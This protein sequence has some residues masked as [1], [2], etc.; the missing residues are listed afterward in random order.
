MF[1][2][3]KI[4]RPTARKGREALWKED[5]RIQTRSERAFD[6]ALDNGQRLIVQL[7]HEAVHVVA[8][9]FRRDAT[10][11]E[12]GLAVEFSLDRVSSAYK[13]LC[14]RDLPSFFRNAR[15]KFRELKATDAAIRELR[16]KT[17]VDAITPSLLEEVFGAS[18]ELA[19]APCNRVS[20]NDADR[21]G[22][23]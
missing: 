14:E 23:P 22:V 6:G 3:E 8:G 5:G 17:T 13:A 1:Q 7:A 16:K 18:P 12:E 21:R 11:F 4:F 2:P 10:L 9:A 19:A 20:I 15:D